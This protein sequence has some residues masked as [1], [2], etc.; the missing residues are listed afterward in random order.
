MNN[1][2]NFCIRRGDI[3]II[4]IKKDVNNPHKQYGERPCVVISNDGNN[5][6]CNAID[7]I[8]LTTVIKKPELP[9]HA[10]LETT[11]CLN[12]R[13]M[14]LCE[15]SGTAD[16]KFIIKKIGTVSERD[17][18]NIENAMLKQKG[19]NIFMFTKNMQRYAFA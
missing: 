14:A 17:M 6:H 1:E 7:Y 4:D 11:Y 2:N 3:V 10:I 16:K 5:R 15:Q 18:F 8:P 9:P 13:S 12:Q 19:I